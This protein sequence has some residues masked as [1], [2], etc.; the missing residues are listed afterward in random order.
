LIICCLNPGAD[1]DG[2]ASFRRMIV[3]RRILYKRGL[4]IGQTLAS[5]SPQLSELRIRLDQ[6]G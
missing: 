5:G 2:G 6:H 4:E 1:I 3:R